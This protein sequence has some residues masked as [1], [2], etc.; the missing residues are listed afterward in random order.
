[1]IASIDPVLVAMHGLRVIVGLCILGFLIGIA[2]LFSYRRD[3]R[4]HDEARRER[5][6]RK[7]WEDENENRPVLPYGSIRRSQP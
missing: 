7:A 5:I 1:M 4:E 3:Q 2:G 6:A